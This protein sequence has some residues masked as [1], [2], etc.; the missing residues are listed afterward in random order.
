MPF[1]YLLIFEL[2]NNTLKEMPTHTIMV[3]EL[4]FYK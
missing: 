2:I 1:I 4:L 3:V